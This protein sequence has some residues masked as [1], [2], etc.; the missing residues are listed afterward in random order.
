[1]TTLEDWT[2]LSGAS[3]DEVASATGADLTQ[4]ESVTGYQRL[5]D[6]DVIDTTGGARIFLRDDD[7]VL[8]YVGE[9]ALPSGTDHDALVKAAGSHGE[10]LRSRQGKSALMH[11]V[12][13]R[14]VAWSEDGGEVGFLE[15]F[16]PTTIDRYR[17]TIYREPPKF[18]R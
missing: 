11:V 17:R 12:A 9:I 3:L 16:P 10:T 13:D 1:M 7:V 15:L 2:H 14:G 6:L 5:K 8:I 4:R 18:K